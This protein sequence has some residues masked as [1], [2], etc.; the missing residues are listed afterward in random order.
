MTYRWK[1][2]IAVTLASLL[3]AACTITRPAVI[4]PT[5]ESIHD[6]LQHRSRPTLL[7]SDSSGRKQW[8]YGTEVLGD[9]LRGR[10]TQTN[11]PDPVA[12]PLDQI[13]GVAASRYSSSRTLLLL[14]GLASLVLVLALNAPS[15]TY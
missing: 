8:V 1:V 10:R 12:I 15:P 3:L 7:I 9:T 11:P 4:N 5:P 13:R 6:Y 2:V 14:G